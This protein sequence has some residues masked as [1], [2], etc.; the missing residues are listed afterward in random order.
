MRKTLIVVAAI[1]AFAASASAGPIL[2]GTVNGVL[3]CA[4]DNNIGGCTGMQL[5]DLDPTAG[6]LQLGDTT[7]GGVT[8]LSSS[9]TQVIGG[10]QN[11]L[12]SQ[13]LQIINNNDFAITAQV[14][15]GGINYTG[16]IEEIE[17]SG[18]GTWQNAGGSTMSMI[19]CASAANVQGGETPSDCPTATLF[20]F[21]D[22]AGSGVDSFSTGSILIPFL[23]AGPYSMTTGFTMN[24]IAGG[25]LISRG[26]TMIS[27]VTAVPEPATMLLLGT[28]LLTAFRARRKLVR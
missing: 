27:D 18:S 8:V 3:F 14:A 1:L 2:A 24:L 6:S 20:T 10:D 23:A 12:N 25:Q 19:W 16:P 15:I 4:V 26:Q 11:V 7:I 22:V 28:G 13:S 9:H 17:L 21:N 5:P